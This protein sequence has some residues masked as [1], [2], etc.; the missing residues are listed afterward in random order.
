DDGVVV[1]ERRAEDVRRGERRGDAGDADDVDV[2]EVGEEVESR[3]GHGIEAGVARA[4]ECDR[5][6]LPRGLDGIA[7]A[8]LLAAQAGRADFGTGTKEVADLVEVLIEAD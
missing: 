4:D 3:A 5:P 8:R 2:I 6:A 1:P 7:C